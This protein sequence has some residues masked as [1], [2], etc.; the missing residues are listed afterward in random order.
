LSDEYVP[1]E[2]WIRQDQM[3]KIIKDANEK[4]TTIYT[5][6]RKAIDFYYNKKETINGE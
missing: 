4:S 3:E 1:V 5:L 6:I 2:L